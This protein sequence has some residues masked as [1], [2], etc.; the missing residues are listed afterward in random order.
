MVLALTEGTNFVV[1]VEKVSF[2]LSIIIVRG[3]VLENTTQCSCRLRRRH[4]CAGDD[5]LLLI[6]SCSLIKRLVTAC[7][8]YTECYCR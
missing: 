3:D 6:L 4:A 2:L 1:V 8:R 7:K 5:E